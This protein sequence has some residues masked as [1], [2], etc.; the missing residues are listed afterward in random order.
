M[1]FDIYAAVTDR[2]IQELEKGVIPWHK[3]WTAFAPGPTAEA[4]A[5]L[6]AC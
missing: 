6:T 2:I 4:R 3:A 1:A 5:G